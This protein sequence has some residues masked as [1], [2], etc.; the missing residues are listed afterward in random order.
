MSNSVK[1]IVCDVDG[2][3]LNKNDNKPSD[4]VFEMIAKVCRRKKLYA[5]A[6]GRSCN[7]LHKLFDDMNDVFFICSDGAYIRKNNRLIYQKP[8][9]KSTLFSVLQKLSSSEFV[10]YGEKHAY[11]S[12]RHVFDI[13][14]DSEN[15]MVKMLDEF[16]IETIAVY[17]LAL[18]KRYHSYAKHY[19]EVNILLRQ[20]YS[21]SLWCEY[22][23]IAANKGNAVEHLQ[24]EYGILYEETA[25]FGDNTNDTHMLKKAYYSY[26][27]GGAKTEIKA[28]A[29]FFTESAADEIVNKFL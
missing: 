2:T 16:D 28:L 14:S 9:A 19:I 27:V 5:L 29:R 17:K 23:D 7:S 6:S 10:L 24:K 13:I 1:L 15:S 11:A 8:I 22:V 3:L 12:S 26:A 4:K 20:C 21:G 25:V 18:F